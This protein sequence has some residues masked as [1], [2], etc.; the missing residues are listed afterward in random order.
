M[1]NLSPSELASLL[2]PIEISQVRQSPV[3]H[4]SADDFAEWVRFADEFARVL[5]SRL[6]PL[7]KAASRVQPNGCK[8]QTAEFVIANHDARSVVGFWQSDRSAEP[9][10]V[11]L[12]PTLVTTFVDRLLGGRPGPSFDESIERR[13]L[14]EI[15]HRLAAR[16]IDVARQ[17]LVE[18]AAVGA[19]DASFELR[20][21]PTQT[22]SF[23]EAWFPD[24]SLLRLSFELRFVQGG[25]WLDLLIPRDMAAAFA[26][27]RS[28]DLSQK[29]GKGL[30]VSS[31]VAF[32]SR[33]I[34]NSK[35]TPVVAQLTRMMLAVEEI[36]S[37]SVGDV[38]LTD[39]APDE[40]LDVRLGESVWLRADSGCQDGHKAIRIQ[41]SAAA[42]KTAINGVS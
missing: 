13:P 27:T 41:A 2:G 14:T 21:L 15:D 6:R 20:E 16:L 4:V 3:A 7:V 38:L 31:S 17:C 19:T 24:G 25:G 1:A 42:K 37:L 26:C 29:Q 23:E 35:Q 40:P 34:P 10:S 9:L 5:S 22:N 33:V 39:V 12:S 30:D 8:S 11:V 32:Q 18:A 28:D 36:Q